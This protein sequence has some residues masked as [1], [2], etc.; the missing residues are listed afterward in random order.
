MSHTPALRLTPTHAAALFLSAF[1]IRSVVMVFAI[2]PYEFY[3]QADS[4][5][6]HYNALSVATGNGMYRIDTHEPIFWRTPGYPPY[7]AFFYWIFGIRG[8][9]FDVNST[10]QC[11]AIWVQIFFASFIPLI[12]FCLAQLLTQQKIIATSCAWIS[13]FHPGLVLASTYLL[14]EGL[15]LIFFYLFLIFFYKNFLPQTS[16]GWI[17]NTIIAALM[18]SMYTWMR[19]MG[20]FVAYFCTFMLAIGAIG[21][22]Y[23]KLARSSLFVILFFAS[24]FPWYWRNHQLTGEWFFCPTIGTYL[25]VFSV[26]KI[27]R[28]ITNKPILE[29]HSI[30]QQAAAI[31]IRKKRLELIGTGKH[32]SNNVCKNVSY[33]IIREYPGY[34]LYDW[35]METVKT[36]FDLYSYQLVAMAND[37]YFYDPIEEFLPDKLVDCLYR[38]PLPWY[39]RF[40]CWFETLF[41][42]LLWMGIFAGLWI[43]VIKNKVSHMRHLWLITLPLIALV[44]GM[45]GGFG[46]ARLRLPAE[47][48][49]IILSLTYWYRKFEN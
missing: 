10:A 37:S 26:P 47:P 45:T 29:C 23:L 20:E 17:I 33:P 38:A 36:T 3:K 4:A 1:L 35:I 22:W 6:Y 31:E 42:L 46:Y 41:G 2:Q 19:P 39:A 11:A 24:I 43:F 7:I 40:T 13:V 18:L 8:L 12:L 21:K 5:D 32:V 44:I 25:N 34:F 16:R 15:A 9:P 28:R 27:L 30:A 14:T 49:L 48:L